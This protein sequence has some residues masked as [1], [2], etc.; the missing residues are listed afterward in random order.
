MEKNLNVKPTR[1]RDFL[2]RIQSIEELKEELKKIKEQ[3]ENPT[4]TFKGIYLVMG[5]K[6]RRDVH[7]ELKDIGPITKKEILVLRYEAHR[8]EYGILAD[9]REA[10]LREALKFGVTGAPVH[11]RDR[12]TFKEFSE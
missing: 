12:N 11:R 4:L 1:F 2:K 9:V 5:H 7:E 6:F 8:T 3:E 10:E